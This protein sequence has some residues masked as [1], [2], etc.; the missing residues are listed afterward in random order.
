M[1]PQ[2]PL[3]PLDRPEPRVHNNNPFIRKVRADSQ[4]GGDWVEDGG[5]RASD[6]LRLAWDYGLMFLFG[7]FV[8]SYVSVTNRYHFHNNEMPP[9]PFTPSWLYEYMQFI[10]YCEKPHIFNRT[11]LFSRAC[12][13]LSFFNPYF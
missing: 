8:Y 6:E 13:E 12:P 4:S 1:A 3:P 11:T 10:V 5:Q 7:L 2:S 9:P